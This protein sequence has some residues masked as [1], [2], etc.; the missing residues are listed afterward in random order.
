MEGVRNMKKL[1]I[2]IALVLALLLSMTGSLAS[3]QPPVDTPGQ[4]PDRILVKFQPGTPDAAKANVNQRLGGKVIGAIPEI[5]VDIVGVPQNQASEK[6]RAY[7]AEK[8]VEFAEPDYVATATLTPDDTYF[9]NQWGLTKIQAPDSWSV[10]TGSS[11]VKIAILDTGIDQDHPDLDSKIVA[12]RNFTT[13]STVDDLYGHGTHCAGIAAAVTNNSSGVAGVG[14]NASLM[15][16]KVL[17]DTGS[18]YYSWI[19]NGIVWATDNGAQVISMSLG[20]SSG[21]ST[22]QNAVNYAWSHGVVVV[23]AAGNNGNTARSY[24]AYYANCIAVAATDQNDAKASFSTY[25]SWVDVAAPGVSVFSTAP[26][27]T[28]YLQQQG[29]FGYNYGYLSGTSMATPFVAG[30]AGLIW[31]TSYGT[32]N[33]SVR[34]RIES[35]ADAIA[36]TGTYWQ[37]GRINAYEAVAPAVPQPP[38]LSVSVS[39]PSL[40]NAASFTVQAAVNN[41]GDATANAAT[42]TLALPSGLST[43]VSLIQSLGDIAGKASTT[44][45]WGVTASADGQYTITVNAAATNASPA[46]GTATVTVNA[47]P[48]AQVQG[49]TVTTVSSSQLNLGWTANTESDL[50]HYNVYRGTVSGGPY[51]VIASP[52]T[53]SYPDTVLTAVTTYYYVVSA[54]DNAGN[55]GEKSPESSNTTN[56]APVN[57]MHVQSITMALRT[58]G[59]YKYATATVTIVDAAGK[60]LSGATVSGHWSSA[61]S[62]SDSGRTNSR[63]QVTLSSNRVRRPPSGTTFTFTVDNIQLSG[64]TYNSASN[65]ITNNSIKV[66]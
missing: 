32:S 19:A 31:S 29:Y 40:T 5:G 61:T 46:S 57:E 10:T 60:T 17:D 41:S 23:A 63:G 49:L 16:V 18:G 4:A 59:T 3:A 15:N 8:K 53:N 43:G 13:S 65:V 50:N 12:N 30:L 48:P 44:V 26:N 20:G 21:S 22:L 52:I 14:F 56:S 62:D 27:H 24:P 39:A 35:T 37:Y 36:G 2:I 34:S 51:T 64:W 6:A 66:Q 1:S 33:T 58:S 9:T 7:G 42:A 28:N 45:S 55:E 47:T 11:D 25:G 54:V 38:S